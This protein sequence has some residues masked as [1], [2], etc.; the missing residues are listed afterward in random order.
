[1]WIAQIR[2][3]P[4][5][6]AVLTMGLS[7]EQLTSAFL[8]GEWSVAQNVH[9]LADSHMHSFIR[10]KLILAE[11]QPT[12]RPYDQ[13]VWATTPEANLPDLRASLMLLRGL[14]ARWADLFA[15]LDEAQWQ[16]TGFHPE[17]GAVSVEK[18]L[19]S[20]AAHGV[21][22]LEQ[23]RRTLAAAPTSR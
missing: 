2:S 23:I 17:Q 1:M 21:A 6:L 5:E 20:Y 22:H 10:L 7:S 11:E 4:E 13:D 8:A 19:R 15:G 16:R 12:L 18:I 3:L 14:H 9:H